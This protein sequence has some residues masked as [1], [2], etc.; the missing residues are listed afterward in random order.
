MG[1]ELQRYTSFKAH[2][3]SDGPVRQILVN[4][5]G[6]VSLSSKNVHMALRRGPPIW[7]VRC[8]A[9]FLAHVLVRANEREPHRHE[10]IKD[11]RCM[12]FTSKG[13]AEILVA[14]L[15]DKML[16]IDL[17]KGEIIKQVS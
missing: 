11:L 1:T 15:Q 8:V 6:V 12:S 16:V 7:H 2:Q 13:T 17:N 4:E 5:K 9:W 10:E 3:A 14:G